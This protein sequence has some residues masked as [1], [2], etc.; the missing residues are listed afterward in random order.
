M[1][2]FCFSEILAA[3][4][5]AHPGR[6]AIAWRDRVVS[7]GDLVERSYRVAHALGVS[8]PPAAVSRWTCPQERVAIVMRNRPEWL[9]AMFGAYAARAVPCNVNYRYVAEEL[10]HVLALL[11]PKAVVYEPE[12]GEVLADAIARARCA[13]RLLHVDDD[14]GLAP[15]DGSEGYEDVLAAADARRPAVAWSPDDRY[16]LLTGG[17]TGLPKAVLWRQA[18]IF[19][20]A[21]GGRRADGREYASLDELM[22]RVAALPRPALAAPPFMHGAAQW[23]AAGSLLSGDTVVIQGNV[24]RLDPADIWSTVERHGVKLLAIVGDAFARPLLAHL[25]HTPHD[26]GS[27]R[28]IVTGGVALSPASKTGFTAVAPNATVLD[29]AGASETGPQLTQRTAP[30]ATEATTGVF[31]L[32]AGSCVLA[33]DR[34]SALPADD[35]SVG[36]LARSGRV[37]LGYLGDETQTTK[38]FPIIDGVRLAIPGDRARHAGNGA[39]ELLGRESITINSGGEK[40]FAEE[41]EQAIARHPSVFDVVVT[42]RPSERWG[43]EVVAVVQ[44]RHGSDATVSELRRAAGTHVASYKLPKDIVFVPAV[45]RSPAGKADYRWAAEVVAGAA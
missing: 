8:S 44:L 13:P 39:V 1:T 41:V 32:A 34:R 20:A 19:V 15:L 3:V 33:E 4:A 22:T 5:E 35:G 26:L 16:A 45:R 23:N 2:E 18:D 25:E 30:G 27:L 7:Y 12:F 31:E 10:A 43:Q 42:G 24:D 11:E 37:P 38:T 21:M 17:T 6:A 29:T 40:I 9:E 36:W 28:F 14:S